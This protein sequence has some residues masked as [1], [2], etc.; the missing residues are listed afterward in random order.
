M[1][2]SLIK[3]NEIE[4]HPWITFL[5][6]LLISSVGVLF[7]MQL[8]YQIQVSGNVLNLTGIF[9][10]IFTIIPSVYFL[11]IF[12]KKQESMDEKDIARHY[13]KGFWTRHD[14]DILIFLFYFF[15]L[16]FSFAFWAFMLPGGT[17]QIQT[18]KI[19]EIRVLAG[20]I[21]SG[22]AASNSVMDFSKVFVNNLQVMMFAFVFSLLF[23]AGAVFIVV[24]NASIL[25]VYIGKLSESLFHIPMVSLSFLPHGIPEIAGYLMAGLAGGVISA[26]IIRGHKM[27]IVIGVVI[28]ALKLLGMA[29]LFVLLGAL[30]ETLDM[31]GKLISIFIF[32]TIFIYIITIAITPSKD[33]K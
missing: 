11:T 33:G 4:R 9:S 16:T 27:E 5:W 2:E 17:F 24:W 23:G 28:D 14:R 7:S 19:Q 22:S 21:L 3:Y 12:I 20:N 13:E 29:F 25:G 18:M 6:A 26:A 32:Y 15:G 31:L 1:L 10:V 30:I 8:S